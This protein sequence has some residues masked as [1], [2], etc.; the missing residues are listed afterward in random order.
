MN[1]LMLAAKI[2]AIVAGT[3]QI[4]GKIKGVSGAEK[5][6]AVLA[7]VP[8][9]VSLI[10]LGVGRD[11]FNDETIASLLSAF[12]D[13]EAAALK[14]REALKAGI[15]AKGIPPGRDV[16]RLNRERGLRQRLPIP[17]RRGQGHGP[18]RER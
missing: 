18:R 8:E 12:I 15:M 10:E 3:M 5:K 1:W 4:V 17:D 13:A 6:A 11:V 9:S 2:P 16:L 7:A 14:A